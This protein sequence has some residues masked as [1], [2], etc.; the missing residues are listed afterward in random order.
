MGNCVCIKKSSGL[1]TQC[2]KLKYEG[3][4]CKLCSESVSRNGGV[5]L[6]GSVSDRMSSGILDYSVGGKKAVS[7]MSVMR[8]LK[9]SRE[10]AC[11]SADRRGWVIPECHFEEVVS[12]RGRPRKE[13]VL[14]GV[15][16]CI[17]KKKRGRPRKEKEVVSKKVGEDLIASLMSD[18]I[19]SEGVELEVDLEVGLEV[20]LGVELEVGLEVGLEGDGARFGD[21]INDDDDDEELKVIQV[22]IGGKEYLKS[23]E[24]MLYDRESHDAIGMW[25]EVGDCID[26]L[27]EEE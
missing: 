15:E 18:Q 14:C 17:E 4:Y 2:K 24:N 11:S 12:K 13:G 20:D 8:K 25:N 23:E 19:M 9:I 22:Y 3:D 27:E 1:Y 10:E 5:G 16:E 7:Y 26:A 21:I 6:Y